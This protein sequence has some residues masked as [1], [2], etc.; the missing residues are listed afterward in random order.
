MR[1]RYVMFWYRDEYYNRDRDSDSKEILECIV[2][3]N[4]NG[5]AWTTRLKWKPEIQII[6]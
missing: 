2:T 3:K 5:E 1:F 4:R 6:V